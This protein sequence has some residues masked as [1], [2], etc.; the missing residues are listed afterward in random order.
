MNKIKFIAK[1]FVIGL[2]SLTIHPQ[3]ASAND[4][5]EYAI[6]VLEQRFEMLD[7]HFDYRLTPEIEGHVK[8]YTAKYRKSTENLLGRSSIYFPLFEKAIDEK[9]LPQELKFLTIIESNLKPYA[10]SRVGAAGLWQ[11][12]KP[13]GRMMGLKIN[14]VVD[15]RNDPIK[16]THAALNYLS[17]LYDMFGDWTLA[18]AAYNCGPGNVKKAI[19]RGNSND[20]W[21]IRKYLP[22][23]T[24]A[25][26]PKFMAASYLMNY[27]L[28]HG[29]TPSEE[30]LEENPTTARIY[31]K[32]DFKSL[33]RIVGMDVKS[34]WRLNPMYIKGYIPASDQGYFLTL[35]EDK[36][37]QFALEAQ[38]E[39]DIVYQP[40]E[41][42]EEIAEVVEAPEVEVSRE[43]IY[44][45]ILEGINQGAISPSNQSEEE[46]KIWERYYS[47][48]VR[49]TDVY[50]E[51][52]DMSELGRYDYKY[53]LDQQG[54]YKDIQNYF[55]RL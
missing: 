22:R 16:S 2:I 42:E 54:S 25:Y 44:I 8:A 55:Y 26:V 21:T 32:T 13:T 10:R 20:Y 28:E 50:N 35:P 52:E 40:I 3:L 53:L 4:A 19:R 29:L 14:R 49:E 37:Y 23:E 45:P 7:G 31:K 11:F 17:Y 36:L 30:T 15:E 34:I 47:Y 39:F 24:R 18:I 9:G 33:A 48:E 27:Y 6:E 41:K 5:S 38:T 1:A 51:D 43:L 12:M 46:Q